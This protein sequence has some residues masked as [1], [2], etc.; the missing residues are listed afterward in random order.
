M[1]LLDSKGWIQADL[2]RATGLP[3]DSIS[4]YVRGVALPTPRSLKKLA[5]QLDVDPV[6]LLPNATQNAIENDKPSLEIRT[7]ASA[8]NVAWLQVNRLVTLRTATAVAELLAQDVADRDAA[9]RAAF[10]R[11]REDSGPDRE[12]D[13][14]AD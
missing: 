11:E 7:S 5:E 1:R 8:P 2:A 14:P 3:K 12:A 6:D 13:A 10:A 4:T 9:R